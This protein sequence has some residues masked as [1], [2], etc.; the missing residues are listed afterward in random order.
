MSASTDLPVNSKPPTPIVL[1]QPFPSQQ[2]TYWSFM[3]NPLLPPLHMSLC[4]LV[5]LPRKA[6]PSP[7]KPKII[8]LPRRN[9]MI[10]HLRWFNSLLQLHLPMVLFISNDQVLIQF[11]A[12]LQRDL[13]GSLPSII[14]HMLL[15]TIVL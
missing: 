14:M 4:V 11:S 13:F 6:L 15:K 9:L 12:L 1:S 5:I 2:Q 8:L 7:L 3:T 10:Y